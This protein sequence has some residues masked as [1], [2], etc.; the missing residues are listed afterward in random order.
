MKCLGLL[1]QSWINLEYSQEE[2][3]DLS[4]PVKQHLV[5][6]RF[7]LTE[8]V[9]V[10]IISGTLILPLCQD[11]LV[12]LTDSRYHSENKTY[13]CLS[14]LIQSTQ[15]TLTHPICY[16]LPLLCFVYIPFLSSSLQL[17]I[18][19]GG[20]LS[21]CRVPSYSVTHYALARFRV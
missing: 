6:Q 2:A 5:V 8:G 15:P 1:R 4:A 14:R 9:W 19:F 20:L 16:T 17:V 13:F 10:W 11:S 7:N 18:D 3:I 21:C 12:T